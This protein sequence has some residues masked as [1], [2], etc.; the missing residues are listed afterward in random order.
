[1]LPANSLWAGCREA[2]RTAGREAEAAGTGAGLAGRGTGD[3]GAREEP[4]GEEAAGPVDPEG[5][6]GA[7]EGAAP[8]GTPG[9]WKAGGASAGIGAAGYWN[10]AGDSGAEPGRGALISVDQSVM[11][12]DM[13]CVLGMM[14]TS[15]VL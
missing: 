3:A 14:D 13:R 12:G 6:A 10:A 9:N 5:D 7:A 15:Q 4:V 11:G 2:G 1:M 8:E